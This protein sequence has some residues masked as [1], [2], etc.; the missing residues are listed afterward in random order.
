MQI[1][2]NHFAFNIALNFPIICAS[3]IPISLQEKYVRFM[4]N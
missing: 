3:L 4:W 2:E 1:S